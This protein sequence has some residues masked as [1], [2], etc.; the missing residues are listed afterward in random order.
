MLV[1]AVCK[2]AALNVDGVGAAV[3]AT[4]VVGT[5]VVASPARIAL[6]GVV[7]A[8][9]VTAPAF[10]HD[11]RHVW[12]VAAQVLQSGAGAAGADCFGCSCAM[13]S[14][15][16]CSSAKISATFGFNP[17]ICPANIACA[18]EQ[19]MSL[20]QVA[21]AGSPGCAFCAAVRLPMQIGSLTQVA[22]AACIGSPQA[23]MHPVSPA[24]G[25]GALMQFLYWVNAAFIGSAVPNAFIRLFV[26]ASMKAIPVII[27]ILFIFM[28]FLLFLFC[29][30]YSVR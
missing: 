1:S 13:A 24:V 14:V 29:F 17:R 5:G 27:I 26:A 2:S 30:I 7:G 8:S 6:T 11:P 20:A 10:A 28:V 18:E 25:H 3:G 22:A 23:V 15:F 9:M 21:I 19:F 4:P 16:A 12:S